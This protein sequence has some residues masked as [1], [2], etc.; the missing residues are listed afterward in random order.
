M[1]IYF[2]SNRIQTVSI[3]N[4]TSERIELCQRVP[5]GT[6]L[7]PLLFSNDMPQNISPICQVLRYADDNMLYTTNEYFNI[8]RSD[9]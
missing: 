4:T 6:V 9:L 3:N 8:V 2:S 7:E 5:Q 1:L